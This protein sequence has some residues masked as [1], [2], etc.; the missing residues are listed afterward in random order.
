MEF[1]LYLFLLGLGI[2]LTFIIGPILKL[3]NQVKDLQ[4]ELSDQKKRSNEPIIQS[5]LGEIVS[6]DDPKCITKMAQY[7]Q[8]KNRDPSS[9][10]NYMLLRATTFIPLYEYDDQ[11]R[12]PELTYYGPTRKPAISGY[13]YRDHEGFVRVLCEVNNVSARA[14]RQQFERIKRS[15]L[16]MAELIHYITL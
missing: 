11:H 5:G 14:L 3:Q 13:R 16:T 15:K 7:I 1:A 10:I 2:I 9:I 6:C 4:D 12:A 8:D